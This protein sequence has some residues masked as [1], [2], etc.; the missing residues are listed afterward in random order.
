LWEVRKKGLYSCRAKL[1]GKTP[2]QGIGGVRAPEG[3]QPRRIAPGPEL[4]GAPESPVCGVLR[5]KCAQISLNPLLIVKFLQ[6]RL[7][8]RNFIKIYAALKQGDGYGG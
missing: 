3:A 1:T 4:S 8:A 6:Q 5:R 7:S 2:A